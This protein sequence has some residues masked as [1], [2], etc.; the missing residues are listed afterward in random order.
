VVIRECIQELAGYGMIRVQH[1]K[2]TVVLDQSEWHVLAPLVQ[3]AYRL[4]GGAEDMTDQAYEVRLVLE[5]NAVG[6]AAEHRSASHLDELD[7]HV[8]AMRSI[9]IDTREVPEFLV[10]DRAFHDVI[11]RATGNMVLRA[12]MRDL[13]NLLAANW[14]S[15]RTTPAQLKVLAEQHAAIAEAIRSRNPATARHAMEAHLRWAKDVETQHASGEN[16]PDGNPVGV[17]D[18]HS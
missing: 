15:S 7:A 16:A 12:M 9:A 4:A 13:H 11:G 14:T 2:R 5:M 18:G 1:G 3:E 8:E 17:S 10:K 6:L